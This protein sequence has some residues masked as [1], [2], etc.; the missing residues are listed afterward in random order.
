M[1]MNFSNFSALFSTHPTDSLSPQLPAFSDQN[2]TEAED[3]RKAEGDRCADPRGGP[4][5]LRLSCC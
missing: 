3:D 2:Q 5:S 4:S 1:K